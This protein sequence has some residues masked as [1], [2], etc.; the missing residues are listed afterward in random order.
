MRIVSAWIAG[1]LLGALYLYAAVAAV[2]NVLGMIGL[3]G[4]LGTGLSA[5]G[6]L[7]LVLGVLI[8]LVVF[9]LALWLGRRRTAWTR[10]LLLAAGIAVVAA[11]QIDVMH[12][13][14][15]SSYFA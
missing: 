3:A 6:W 8:P 9:G 4:A 2:G 5:T 14:P 1:V 10:I 12:V 7:W 15:E 13:I 11:L